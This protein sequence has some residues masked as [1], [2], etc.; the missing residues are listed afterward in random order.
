MVDNYEVRIPN[1][2]NEY[3]TATSF[4]CSLHKPLNTTNVFRRGKKKQK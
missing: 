4:D 2:D 1:T 3:A